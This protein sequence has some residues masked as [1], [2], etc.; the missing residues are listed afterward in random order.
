MKR[1]K[2]V[3]SD[4]FVGFLFF[5]GLFVDLCRVF[6]YWDARLNYIL[7]NSQIFGC[8]GRLFPQ[9]CRFIPHSNSDY[10]VVV[11]S[12]TDQKHCVI[13]DI[14]TGVDTNSILNCDVQL[15]LR[16][17]LGHGLLGMDCL[18]LGIV[19]FVLQLCIQFDIS[20]ISYF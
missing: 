18:I 20:M 9:G 2:F 14:T 19:M 7:Q 5:I 15:R 10:H 1:S 11:Y 8:V 3:Y 13:L 12:A 16:R 17:A 4:D 6:Y